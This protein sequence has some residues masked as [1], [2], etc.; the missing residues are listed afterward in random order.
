VG[1]WLLNFGLVLRF[2]AE[3]SR[4]PATGRWPSD[5]KITS[6]GKA[7]KKKSKAFWRT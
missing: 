4:V 7:V 2:L 1:S 5:L 6:A 3:S